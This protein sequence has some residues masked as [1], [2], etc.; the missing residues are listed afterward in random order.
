[1]TAPTYPG[2]T[3][4]H[5]ASEMNREAAVRA[6]IAH[7]A[8]PNRPDAYGVDCVGR[9]QK[10][11]P[12]CHLSITYSMYILHSGNKIYMYVYYRRTISGR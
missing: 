12:G 11:A 6:L 7:Y 9:V 10:A 8:D 4:L 1:M 3:P 2:T 5:R